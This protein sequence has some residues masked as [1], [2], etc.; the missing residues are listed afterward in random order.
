MQAPAPAPG[1]A[2]PAVSP[3]ELRPK[4]VACRPRPLYQ[5]GKGWFV[6]VPRDPVVV[7]AVPVLPALHLPPPLATKF[8]EGTLGVDER[9][10]QIDAVLRAELGVEL[11]MVVGK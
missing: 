9:I 8:N 11:K 5:L 4:E 10:F 2:W 7:T 3:V 6:P 1:P